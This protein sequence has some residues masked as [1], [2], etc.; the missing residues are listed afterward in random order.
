[1]EVAFRL[2]NEGQNS[3]D[4]A[5]Y[6]GR[7]DER[8]LPVTARSLETVIRLATAHAKAR[9]SPTVEADPDVAGAMDI[10]SFALY[11][12]NND[13]VVADEGQKEESEDGTEQSQS[14][15][16]LEQQRGRKRVRLSDG[17]GNAESPKD[18]TIDLAT[19][20]PRIWTELQEANGE[21][22]IK[23]VCSD[24]A[25]RALVKSAVQELEEQEKVMVDEETVYLV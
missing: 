5:R 16:D 15:R 25:D 19:L 18:S 9:L 2:D 24:I 7:Q 11:H 22:E 4:Y 6:R 17:N 12:E 14:S 3:L 21:K 23:N 8:T 1:M 13:T 10:L 20:L